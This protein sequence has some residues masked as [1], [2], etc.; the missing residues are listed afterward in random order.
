MSIS[1]ECEQCHRRYQVADD[2]AGKRGRCKQCGNTFKIP[3]GPG[4]T[5]EDIYALEADSPSSNPP[6][7]QPPRGLK[8]KRK[9]QKKVSGL[10]GLSA[11]PLWGFNVYRGVIV[12]VLA[13]ALLASGVAKFTL[14]LIGAFLCVGPFIA[15]GFAYRFGVAFSDGLIAGLLYMFFM[16]YR[17]HYRLTHRERFQNLRAPSLTLRDFGLLLLGLCFLPVVILAAKDMD[18]LARNHPA[19]VDWTRLVGRPGIAGQP[20]GIV[21]HRPATP[22]LLGLAKRAASKNTPAEPVPADVTAAEANPSGPALAEPAAEASSCGSA[23]TEPAAEAPLSRLADG[24]PHPAQKAWRGPELGLLRFG[25]GPHRPLLTRSAL[26]AESVAIGPEATV[27]ITVNGAADSET[28][29][30]VEPSD[31]RDPENIEQRMACQLQHDRQQD[32]FSCGP[33]Y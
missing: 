13:A 21:P 7:D 14:A 28:C 22:P 8:G 5:A 10:F 31:H 23:P 29:A 9:K 24:D 20:A 3:A 19:E 4:L 25:Q 12:A 30:A 6:A 16:P 18:K 15:C 27:T 2:L 26:Q 32:G 33:S 11:L 1:F 17:I